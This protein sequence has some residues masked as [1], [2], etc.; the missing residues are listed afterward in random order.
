MI[1]YKEQFHFTNDVGVFTVNAHTEEHPSDYGN[2]TLLRFDITSDFP[3]ERV[4][5]FDVRYE[6][7][8]MADIVRK[9]LKN[10]FGVDV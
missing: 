3:C 4:M 6:G 9:L 1:E 2:G 10:H 8:D 7:N 5:F